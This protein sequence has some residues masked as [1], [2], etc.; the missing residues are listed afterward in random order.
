MAKKE[1]TQSIA[2]GSDEQLLIRVLAAAHGLKPATCARMLLVR[3]LA[4]FLDDGSLRAERF[5]QEVFDEL[6]KLVVKDTQLSRARE[7]VLEE[8]ELKNPERMSKR[9]STAKRKSK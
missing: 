5:E 4:D 7:I 3:G 6:T 1:T 8:L 2:M 9:M